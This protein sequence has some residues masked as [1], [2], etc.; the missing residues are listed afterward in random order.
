MGVC[1]FVCAERTNKMEKSYTKRYLHMSYRRIIAYICYTSFIVGWHEFNCISLFGVMSMEHLSE[2]NASTMAAEVANLSLASMKS[3]ENQR[4]SFSSDTL[5]P[6]KRS[7]ERFQTDFA[8]TSPMVGWT[9]IQ[10]WECFCWNTTTTG[11][12]VN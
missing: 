2:N 11:Y 4:E 10:G 12:E 7:M 1:A 6:Q 9:P 8:T 5:L 3:S